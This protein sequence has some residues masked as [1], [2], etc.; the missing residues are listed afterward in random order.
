M[1]LGFSFEG[2][3]CIYLFFIYIFYFFHKESF[4]AHRVGLRC[5]CAAE[6]CSVGQSVKSAQP[7]FFWKKRRRL[8]GRGK[9]EMFKC[10]TEQRKEGSGGEDKQERLER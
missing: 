2:K 5:P 8:V 4:S 1:Q 7:F 3:N 10:I 9:D 6:G